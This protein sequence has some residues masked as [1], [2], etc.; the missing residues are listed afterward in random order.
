MSGIDESSPI[1]M[2]LRGV[3][4]ERISTGEYGP[5]HLTADQIAKIEEAKERAGVR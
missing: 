1:F 5:I 3:V 4:R 2:Q